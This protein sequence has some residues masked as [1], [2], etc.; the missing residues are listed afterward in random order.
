MIHQ[1]NKVRDISH[2]LNGDYD[3]IIASIY[4]NVCEFPAVNLQCPYREDNKPS[5]AL[6]YY[7]GRV[8]FKD[9]ATGDSG[10]IIQL[11]SRIW[12]SDIRTTCIKIL[13]NLDTQDIVDLKQTHNKHINTEHCDISIKERKWD[14]KTL[15]YWK[16]YN[17]T[18]KWLEFADVVP[19]SAFWLNSNV[20]MTGTCAYAY[21][22]IDEEKNIYLYKI[23][24]PLNKTTKWY[25]NYN[26]SIISLYDRLPQ[27]DKHLILCSS[28]KD[29]LCVW[30][31]TGIPCISLQSEVQNIPDKV[32]EL[33]KRFEYMYIL[34]D[35]DKTGLEQGKKIAEQYG[36]IN[37]VL[38]Q[39]NEYKDISDMMKCCKYTYTTNFIK[40][41]LQK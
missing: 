9:F 39:S 5:F 3:L 6:Q 34:Y 28:L 15:A 23:Y 32:L 21:K 37:I 18:Q 13:D 33:K 22:T 14:I 26:S 30:S 27:Q 10:N 36:F 1:S 24:Q 17:I 12:H 2:I 7:E 38:P 29:A 11:L 8:L 25:S 31:N 19:I 16:D 4:L 35:N 40:N 20:H 41:S